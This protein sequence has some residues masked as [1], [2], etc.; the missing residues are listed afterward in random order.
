MQS[1]DPVSVPTTPASN[2]HHSCAVLGIAHVRVLV[3]PGE[4][5][6]VARQLKT[7]VG[8]SPSMFR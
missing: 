4:I 6:A 7:V 1:A 3:V 5:E 2:T 8:E